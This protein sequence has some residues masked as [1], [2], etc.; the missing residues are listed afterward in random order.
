MRWLSATSLQVAL[1]VSVPSP[2]LVLLV[3][4]LAASIIAPVKVEFQLTVTSV[5]LFQQAPLAA[6]LWL[7]LALGAVGS[8]RTL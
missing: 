4:Q 6:G 5:L 1:R 3:V 7:G 2:L 8:M